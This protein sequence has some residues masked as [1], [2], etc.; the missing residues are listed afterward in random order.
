MKTKRLLAAALLC[1]LPLTACGTRAPESTPRKSQE[2]ISSPSVSWIS[3]EPVT[4]ETDRNEPAYLIVAESQDMAVGIPD[5]YLIE[6]GDAICDARERGLTDVEVMAS[7]VEDYGYGESGQLYAA[8][9]AFL[10][11]AMSED[12]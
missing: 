5:S 2:P 10:C 1:A 4:E 3:P 9:T 11:P 8:A 6:L 7:L 12:T